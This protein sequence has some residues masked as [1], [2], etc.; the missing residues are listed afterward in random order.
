MGIGDQIDRGSVG[1]DFDVLK[2]LQKSNQAIA[3][4]DPGTV[5]DMQDPA[6]GMGSFLAEGRLTILITVELDLR[7]LDQHFLQTRRPLF[8]EDPCSFR[9][10]STRTGFQDILYQEIHGII[11]SVSD[12]S[13]LGL[14]GVGIVQVR[15]T[16]Q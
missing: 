15:R 14:E 11:R 2:F 1:E 16:G 3:D 8:C 5:L 9:M 7:L 13:A 6:A 12:N 4:G 10:G